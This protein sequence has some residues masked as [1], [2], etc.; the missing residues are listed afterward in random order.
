MVRPHHDWALKVDFKS[1]DG[2]HSA[3]FKLKYEDIDG[4]AYSYT[5]EMAFDGMSR[6]ENC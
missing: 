1:G 2:E 3:R 4:R 6:P 5:L